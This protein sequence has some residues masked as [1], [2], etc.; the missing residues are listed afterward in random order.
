MGGIRWL[1]KRLRQLISRCPGLNK[2][3]VG[4]D[5]L[6]VLLGVCGLLLRLQARFNAHGLFVLQPRV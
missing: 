2:L 4:Q 6:V 3:K 5:Q 1:Q